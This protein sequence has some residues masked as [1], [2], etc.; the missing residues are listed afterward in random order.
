MIK[1][2]LDLKQRVDLLAASGE[3]Y[4]ELDDRPKRGQVGSGYG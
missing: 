4:D 1:I 2:N 3:A